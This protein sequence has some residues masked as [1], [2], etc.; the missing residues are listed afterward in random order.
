MKKILKFKVTEVVEITRTR[1][2]D[3]EMDHEDSSIISIRDELNLDNEE[4]NYPLHILTELV[5]KQHSKE[6]DMTEQVI[7]AIKL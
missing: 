6:G 7:K 3:V 4:D 2:V 1:V 5:R